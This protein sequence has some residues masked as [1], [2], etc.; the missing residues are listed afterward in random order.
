MVNTKV[1]NNHN[2]KLQNITTLQL[3]IPDHIL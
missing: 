3:T 1:L 2:E